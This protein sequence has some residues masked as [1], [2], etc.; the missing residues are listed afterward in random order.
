VLLQRADAVA[1]IVTAPTALRPLEG[2]GVF[3]RPLREAI[4]PLWERN[5]ESDEARAEAPGG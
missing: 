1:E 2:G 3:A 4:V 5:P